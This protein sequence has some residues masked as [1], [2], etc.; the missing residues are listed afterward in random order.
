MNSTS[1]NDF[2][3]SQGLWRLF[4]DCHVYSRFVI[5][6]DLISKYHV[7]VCVCVCCCCTS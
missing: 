6:V 3:G 2:L 7:F 1:F 4:K 5:V